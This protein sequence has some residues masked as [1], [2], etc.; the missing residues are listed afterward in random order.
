MATPAATQVPAISPAEMQI[1][2]SRA[3]LVLN[4][5]QVA[6]LV[7]AWRQLAGLVGALPRERALADDMALAFRLPPPAVP[8]ASAKPAAG[9]AARPQRLARRPAP[10]PAAPA[11]AKPKAAAKPKTR[12]RAS[13]KR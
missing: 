8:A 11:K 1:L 3:G 12:G 5:G 2:I 4:P 7:L 9:T 13:P 10:K 6:D